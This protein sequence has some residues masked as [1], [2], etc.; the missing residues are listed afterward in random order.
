MP[1]RI[2]NLCTSWRTM[3]GQLHAT[4]ALP[5]SPRNVTLYVQCYNGL[6]VRTAFGNALNVESEVRLQ[7]TV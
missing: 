5:P 4:G 3:N 1:P 2:L 7:P 6:D